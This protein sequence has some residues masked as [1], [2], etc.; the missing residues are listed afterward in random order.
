MG[1][2]MHIKSYTER[3]KPHL[4]YMAMFL[5]L[6]I[7]IAWSWLSPYQFPW[8]E[9]VSSYYPRAQILKN[10]M[11]QHGDFL[12]L[13]SPYTMS[14]TPYFAKADTVT[15]GSLLYFFVIMMPP[16][17]AVKLNYLLNIF[18]A[19]LFM[20]ILVLYLGYERRIAFIAGM[21]FVLNGLFTKVFMWGWQTTID[22]Y[23]LMPLALLFTI[24]AVMEKE[25]IRNSIFLAI[26]FALQIYGGPDLK[27]FLFT[28][29][30]FGFYLLFSLIGKEFRKRLVKIAL[31]GILVALLTFGLTAFKMLPAKEY[32]DASSR[33]KSSFEEA[34]K[35][36]LYFKDFFTRLVEPVGKGFGEIR[37][38][39]AGD[40]IGLVAAGLALFALYRRPKQKLVWF[41]AFIILFALLFANS[42]FV[43]YFLWKYVPPFDS[44]RYADRALVLYV[45]AASILAAIGAAEVLRVLQKR[46]DPKKIRI[47]YAILVGLL[48]V[49]LYVF[50]FNN[51]G[52]GTRFRDFR[53]VLD[54]HEILK[55]IA[56]QPGIF[57]MQTFETRGID[58]GTEV[59][60]IPYDIQHIYGYEGAWLVEYMNVHLAYA[61][62]EPAKF[63]GMLNV[64]YVTSQQPLNISGFT[65]V[66]RFDDCTLCYPELQPIQKSWGPY[67]YENK[68]FLPRAILVRDA[69]LIAGEENSA[70]QLMYGLMLQPGFNPES[71]VIILGKQ[72]L[73]EYSADELQRFAAVVLTQGSIDQNSGYLLQ[74]Y[75]D[76]GGI[77]MPDVLAGKNSISGQE[78]ASLL[79]NL[80]KET[81]HGIPDNNIEEAGFEEK[82]VSITRD[83]QGFL[84]MSEL[85]SMYP[86]WHAAADRKDAS[87]YRAN[88]VASAVYVQ[89]NEKVAFS[90]FPNSLKLGLAITLA[91]LLAIIS[92]FVYSRFKQV[93]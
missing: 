16:L 39:G 67:L 46:Y 51:V 30:M 54:S 5:V 10:S 4:P 31:V 91:T 2:L 9:H 27:V 8:G 61:L 13:W 18:L 90:Y 50:G 60:T 69:I 47:F 89:N 83:F 65:L 59:Y 35:R 17:L 92:F 64:K 7:I 43:F 52:F 33:P 14:G 72:R 56:G 19:S 26:I 93:E 68:E 21:L 55:Y 23:V 12:P 84:V 74:Q 24:K 66:K 3:I 45:F 58:W 29:L 48:F 49:N 77:I 73:N 32:I 70:K 76:A 25:W 81:L 38:D 80:G 82:R 88:G 44:F 15:V 40:H 1:A 63:W 86:G 6:T 41:L 75:K 79:A 11:M 57:R 37:R 36:T 34:S 62:S 22:A 20:Y 78:I 85:Y 53:Q 87:I 42:S 28:A 71:T